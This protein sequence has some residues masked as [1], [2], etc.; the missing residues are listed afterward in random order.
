MPERLSSAVSIS[1]RAALGVIAAGAVGAS[2]WPRVPRSRVNAPPGRTVIEYWE[3]WTGPEGDAVQA[4]VDRFNQSQ[5]R[6][7]VHRVPVSEIDTKAMVAIGGGDPP[8][9]VGVFSYNVPQYAQSGAA[10]PLDDFVP[11][12]SST[13]R[14]IDP[15]IYA[16]AVRRLLSFDGR[17]W[18]G[19]SS[20][21][22]LALYYNRAMFHQAGLDPN[23]PPRSIPELDSMSDRLLVR[24]QDGSIARAG[25]LQNLPSWW[26]YFWPVMFGGGMYDPV[27]DRAVFADPETIAA[28]EWVGSYPRRIGIAQS[29][30]FSLAYNTN[31]HSPQDPFISGR[32]AMIVQGPWMANFIRRYNPGMDYAAVPVPV[33][34]SMLADHDASPVGMLEADVLMVPRNCRHPE[35]AFEFI[36][37]TQR[38]DEQE[39][40]ATSHCKSSP[41]AE[42]SPGFLANHPNRSVAVFDAITKS[43]RARIL[44]QTPVWKSYAHL[45]EGAFD[46]VWNGGDVKTICTQVEA[47][48]Q[49]MLDKAARVRA[50][51]AKSLSSRE[52]AMNAVHPDGDTERRHPVAW[53]RP[54][55][56]L[57][58]AAVG[59]CSSP[60]DTGIR[61]RAGGFA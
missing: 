12:S 29:R 4:V 8:D 28:Y 21:Y 24:N 1:R 33:A 23:T 53:A 40:L 3:K 31:F 55:A 56:S 26:P 2:L 46:A 34:D 18:A 35:E 39:T 30:A 43:Q 9:V 38:Q 54:A 58:A 17:L 13:R 52:R 57:D 36:K 27:N 42:C 61:D 51:R 6:I 44:P 11:S 25:F 15:S 32:V 48:A 47:R 7:W 49:N 59:R 16:P 37:F 60:I 41:L 20:C 45:T 50:I 19:I 22:S 14:G 10:L 5:S